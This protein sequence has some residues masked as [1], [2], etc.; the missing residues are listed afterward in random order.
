[1][2]L[3]AVSTFEASTNAE[4]GGVNV[5]LDA[6]LVVQIGLFLLLLVILKPLLFDPLLKLFE[7]REK[8]IEGTRREATKEDERSAKAL[9]KYEGVLAKAR[10]AGGL[11]RDQ[12]RAEGAKKEAEI[13]ARVR[14]QTAATLEQGR[15]AIADE[16]KT[17]RAALEAESAALGGAIASRVLGREVSP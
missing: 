11:E 14:A 12:L 3:L 15:K 17:A 7:E 2:S 9:A 1:M 16:A 8:R 4:G 10:E 5:D 13:M 6:S